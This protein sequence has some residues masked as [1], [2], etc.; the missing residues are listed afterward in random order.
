M[1]QAYDMI[2]IGAGPAGMSAAIYAKRAGMSALVL[3]KTGTNGGQVLNTYEVDNYPGL[4]GISGFDLCMKMKEHMD[5]LEVPVISADVTKII[6]QKE[7]KMV[8]T[9]EGNYITKTVII[10]AG[11]HHAKLGVP[12]EEELAGMG[13]SY[14]ATCDGAFFKGREVAVIGGGDVAVEDAL[15]LA[16]AC[17]KVYLIHR[18]NEL[19]AARILQ[20]ALFKQPN[21]EVVWEH[22]VT[23]IE[24]EEQVEA[25]LIQNKNT[26]KAQKLSV[27]GVFVAVGNVPDSKAFEGVVKLDEK[28]YIVAEEDGITSVPGIFAAGDI[29]TKKLR[30]IVTAAADG[31]CAV[32]SAEQYI[33]ANL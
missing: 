12:G 26:K 9:E 17:K 15:F 11:A 10:A 14:C 33:I 20:E 25:L 28:G 2:I 23:G 6:D 5:K 7:L 30:Q 3:E 19:R 13:V 18:R 32:N 4:P 31:A 27:S 16:R 21:I 29:R 24:G 8:C 22:V 1:E